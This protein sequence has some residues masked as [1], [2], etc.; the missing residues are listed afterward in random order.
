[1]PKPPR[2]RGAGRSERSDDRVTHR[3]GVR[4]KTLSTKAGDLTVG[5][6]KLRKGS[7]FPSSAYSNHA[8]G[9]TKRLRGDHGGVRQ[10][11]VDPFG[12]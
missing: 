12:R 3:N 5:I 11:C 4:A 10:R 7:F 9:S 1:M 8:V 2:R 6:P